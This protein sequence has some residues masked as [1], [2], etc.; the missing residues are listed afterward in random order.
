M[1]VHAAKSLQ[2]C[3]TLWDPIDGSPLGS[4]TPGILQ[5]R[6][7]EW[8]AISFSN[9]WKWRVKVKSKIEVTQS[10]LTPQRPHRLQPSRLLHPWDLPGKSTG[11]GCHCLLCLYS[12]IS[13]NL[14]FEFCKIVSLFLN[15]RSVMEHT[16]RGSISW[17]RTVTHSGYDLVYLSRD[18]FAQLD[19]PE[20][21]KKWDMIKVTLITPEFFSRLIL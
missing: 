10:C 5:A 1:C 21:F 6:T 4:P 19:Y 9:A 13:L 14:E 2:S 11:V 3:P 16:R 15:I 18:M 20:S 12:E 8:V 7:L 17:I